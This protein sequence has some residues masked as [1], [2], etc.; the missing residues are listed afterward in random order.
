MDSQTRKDIEIIHWNWFKHRMGKQCSWEKQIS[1]SYYEFIK[2]NVSLGLNQLND[3]EYKK[4]LQQLVCGFQGYGDD[5]QDKFVCGLPCDGELISFEKFNRFN[6][7]KDW[8]NAKSLAKRPKEKGKV[9]K[10]R[11]KRAKECVERLKEAFGYNDL[12]E[13]PD[14][15][16][17]STWIN[18]N[19]WYNQFKSNNRGRDWNIKVLF[20]ALLLTV[21]PYC[22]RQYIYS[23][24]KDSVSKNTAEMDHFYPQSSYPHLSCSL[25][26]LIP[27]CKVCNR[28]KLSTNPDAFLYPYKQ[29]YEKNPANIVA[30]FR[31]RRNDR[32]ELKFPISADETIVKIETN[33]ENNSFSKKIHDAAGLLAIEELYTEH[34][35]DLNDLLSRYTLYGKFKR[36]DLCRLLGFSESLMK[37]L[38]YGLPIGNNKNEEYPLRKFKKDILEQLEKES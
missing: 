1:K 8:F 20:N 35:L 2:E 11:K 16:N 13:S 36:A 26:N 33:D 29:S 17:W 24:E 34:K 31:I 6:S 12:M 7:K 28:I 9:F 38:V 5:E 15:E 14:Y 3:V 25:Y 23:Y 30:S 22:N 19:T 37:K 32:A 10:E 21:C 27:S 18:S 4:R